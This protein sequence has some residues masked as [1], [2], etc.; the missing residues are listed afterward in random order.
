MIALSG[1]LDDSTVRLPQQIYFQAPSMI[2][3][4]G[5]LDDCTALSDS[6]D[7]GTAVSGPLYDCLVMLFS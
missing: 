4:S 6:F 5:S 2:A 3:L 1:S 7:G